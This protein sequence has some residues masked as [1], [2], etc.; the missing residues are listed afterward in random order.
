MYRRISL[1]AIW[2]R[3][4]H[5]RHILYIYPPN[6]ISFRNRTLRRDAPANAHVPRRHVAP[7]VQ[8]GR[9]PRRAVSELQHPPHVQEVGDADAVEHGQARCCRRWGEEG[10]VQPA[11]EAGGRAGFEGAAV[12]NCVKCFLLRRSEL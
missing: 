11:D 9:G 3:H 12:K 6:V 8:L 2:V 4:A 10:G 1:K 7:D 5:T